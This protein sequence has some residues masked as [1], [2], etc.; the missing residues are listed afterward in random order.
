METTLGERL[1]L[2]RK[3]AGLTQRQLAQKI[4]C[5]Q[6]DLWRIESG[7]VQD[8]HWSRMVALAEALDVSLD[9]LAGKKGCTQ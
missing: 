5:A 2:F 6:S 9:A 8:P 4:D 1:V 7:T 3:R